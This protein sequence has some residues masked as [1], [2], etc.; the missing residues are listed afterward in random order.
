M[1]QAWETRKS[2]EATKASIPLQR[3]AA[4]AALLNAQAVINSER[5]WVMIQIQE[6]M[7]SREKTNEGISDLRSFRFSIFNYGKSPA[8]ILNCKML[9][10]VLDNPDKT[11]PIP[12]D[13]GTDEW[14]KRFLAPHDS[15]PISAEIYPSNMKLTISA[16]SADRGKGLR[17]G[18]LVTYGLIEYSD[19][20]STSAYKTAFCY[21]HEK[22]LLSSM[23]GHFVPCGPEVYNSY[24]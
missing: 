12:P 23:G 10:D 4:E 18:E 9:F 3:Q 8:H 24:S 17:H 6:S 14:R 7:V 11:L 22:G 5:P 21:R 19:G 1:W 20:I 16:Q 13:Y 2:A 15:F